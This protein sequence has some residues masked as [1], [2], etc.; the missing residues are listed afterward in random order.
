M[1]TLILTSSGK[2]IT[3]NNVD[4]YLPKKI[5]DC[6]IAYISTASKQVQNDT[7][8]I[9]H[10]K[11]MDELNFAYTEIDIAGMKEDDLREKL[12]GYDI[13]YVE[14]GN[15]FYLLRAVLDSGFDK[16]IKELLSQGVVYIGSSAGSY[17]ACPSIVMSTFSERGYDR[18]GLTDYKAMNLVSFVMKA[19]YT[20]DMMER[21]KKDFSDTGFPLRILTDNQ[22]LL[23]QDAKVQL[24]GGGEEIVM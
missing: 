16:I 9:N 13:V 4:E 1:G 10:K 14:G 8:A 20:S 5:T 19:H 7:Y 12:N 2:Y 6:K 22:A 23:V 15:T 3:N 11:K 24:L 18:C 17:I 21:L